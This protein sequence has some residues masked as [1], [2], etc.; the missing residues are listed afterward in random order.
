MSVLP[1]EGYVNLNGQRYLGLFPA[2]SATGA[3]PHRKSYLLRCEACGHTYGSQIG[4]IRR[5]QCPHC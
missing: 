3:L 5:R 2:I 1:R 4:D